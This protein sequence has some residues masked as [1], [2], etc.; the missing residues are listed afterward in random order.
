MR[1]PVIPDS[2]E[3]PP[4]PYTPEPSDLASSVS[5]S[6]A[7]EPVSLPVRTIA[8]GATEDAST[9]ASQVLDSS[10]ATSSAEYAATRP[11][12]RGETLRNE[13]IILNF[14]THPIVCLSSTRAEEFNFPEPVETFFNRDVTYKDWNTLK[15]H[16]FP[17]HLEALGGEKPTST[18]TL[19]QGRQDQVEA[20]LAEWNKG[21][22]GPRRIALKAV[23]EPAQK[24]LDG[25][26]REDAMPV[27]TRRHHRSASVS[28]VASVASTTSSISSISSK[29]FES[30]PPV[31]VQQ[32]LASFRSDP[33]NKA[34]LR[35]AVT[36]LR[37]KFRAQANTV[38]PKDRKNFRKAYKK[39]HKELKKELRSIIKD[40]WKEN[41]AERKAFRKDS[42]A[43]RK[44]AWKARK[45]DRGD[46]RSRRCPHARAERQAEYGQAR[47]RSF[48]CP[49]A[50]PEEPTLVQNAPV[51]A[52]AEPTPGSTRAGFMGNRPVPGMLPPRR[53]QTSYVGGATQGLGQ[54]VKAAEDACK[55]AERHL[56]GVTRRL[57]GAL[58]EG[59]RKLER[60]LRGF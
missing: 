23:F 28:S 1:V 47:A 38:P 14:L 37:S 33:T 25:S 12:T 52:A 32:L 3:P 16:L 24:N 35:A 59:E 48:D 39:E 27:T 41:H 55:L 56:E 22:F 6:V 60:G 51:Q 46:R 26:L 21:F 31:T 17:H 7:G 34:H 2:P 43:E 10:S 11:F 36:D 9:A 13:G 19:T 40:V 49:G 20:V 15:S 57:D 58:E 30:I 53:S 5:P 50:Y 45:Q 29:D 8:S 54:W 42:K 44:E 4:P 18:V